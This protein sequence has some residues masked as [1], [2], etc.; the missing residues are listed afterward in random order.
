M[1]LSICGE[2]MYTRVVSCKLISQILRYHPVIQLDSIICSYKEEFGQLSSYF[3][4]SRPIVKA[5][6]WH[7]IQ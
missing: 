6:H 3:M 2:Y 7:I 4:A 5:L 1:N